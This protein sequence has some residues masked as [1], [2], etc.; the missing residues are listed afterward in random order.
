MS[1]I[2]AGSISLDS[3][4]KIKFYFSAARAAI[5]SVANSWQNLGRTRQ[6]R[7]FG[8]KIRPLRKSWGTSVIFTFLKAFGL[9]KGTNYLSL[10]EQEKYNI[11]WNFL[12]LERIFPAA[13]LFVSAN[14]DLCG[15]TIS[16]LRRGKTSNRTRAGIFKE[17]MGARNRGG[18]GLSH[19]PARP[20]W[21]NSFLVIDS[22]A[23]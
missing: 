23:P 4:F 13:Q 10:C 21:R 14:F 8:R 2:S 19:R 18:I 12:Q 9:K 6:A 3:T 17:S 16:Q 20:G 11:S 1:L 22:W 7:Q 5:A 15:Q